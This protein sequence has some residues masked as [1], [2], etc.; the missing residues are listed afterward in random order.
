MKQVQVENDSTTR[1]SGHHTS[2]KV[3]FGYP[4]AEREQGIG[5]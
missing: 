2:T 3:E 4:P 1:E 5:R